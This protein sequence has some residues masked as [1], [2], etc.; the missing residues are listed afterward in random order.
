MSAHTETDDIFGTEPAAKPE[1]AK[2]AIIAK[3]KAATVKAN[4]ATAPKAAAKPAAKPA[5]KAAAKPK[6]AAPAKPAV[7]AEAKPKPKPAAKETSKRGTKTGKYSAEVAAAVAKLKALRAGTKA[8]TRELAEKHEPIKT[9]AFLA[10]AH[11]LVPDKLVKLV[12]ADR[13]NT[14]TRL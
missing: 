6:A 2:P 7:K 11:K 9:W 10:A 1:A 12:N 8:T 5:V 4:G 13:V 3:P 14:I